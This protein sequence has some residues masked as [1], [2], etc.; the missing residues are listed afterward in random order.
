MSDNPNPPTP[1]DDDGNIWQPVPSDD[2]EETLSEEDVIADIIPDGEGSVDASFDV[3]EPSLVDTPDE[4]NYPEDKID[5]RGESQEQLVALMAQDEALLGA[6][7]LDKRVHTTGSWENLIFRNILEPEPEQLRIEEALASLS[8]EE[9]TLLVSKIRNNDGKVILQTGNIIQSVKAGEVKTVSGGEALLAFECLD[10]GGGYRI[11]LYNSGFTIDVI[12]P[13]GNDLQTMFANIVASERELGT[14]NGGQY[15]TYNN[16]VNKNQLL[17]FLQPLII[18]SSYNEWRKRGKLWAAIKL[19]DLA[20]IMA[21]LAHI[22]YPKGFDG[23][24]VRCTRPARDDGTMCNHVEELKINISSLILTRKAA[25]PEAAITHLVGAMQPNASFGIGKIAEYQSG[26]GIEGEKISFPSGNSTISFTMRI[27][28]IAEHLD[29]GKQF[30]AD[31][32]NEIEGDNNEG[33]L[34]QFGLRYIR[35]FLPWIAAVEKKLENSDKAVR[36]TDVK[37]IT[38]ELEKLDQRQDELKLYDT[39]RAYINKAQLTYVGYPSTPCVVCGYTADT[40]SGMISF[41]PF[42]AFF[43]IAFQYLMKSA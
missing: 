3:N 14:A 39:L 22:I 7:E 13:T 11:P 34:E 5:L 2:Q 15:F 32:I 33:R 42:S 24:L 28:S 17:T 8:P 26:L 12:V 38:R 25:L 9:R 6:A 30:I 27:P 31:I 41:D 43:I 21:T 40:P 1:D 18:N 19:P 4:I 35:T 16:V 10:K 20:A 37:Q 23:F 36:T 29:A